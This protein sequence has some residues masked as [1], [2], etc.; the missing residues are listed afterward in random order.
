LAQP[1]PFHLNALLSCPALFSDSALPCSPCEVAAN[2]LACVSFIKT[3][4]DTTQSDT[5]FLG[6][7]IFL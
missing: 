2:W 1:S 6:E 4:K 3:W 7:R 5:G